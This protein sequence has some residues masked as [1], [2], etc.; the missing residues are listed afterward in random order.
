MT[1]SRNRL[2]TSSSLS[3][4]LVPLSL[5]CTESSAAAA[6]ALPAGAGADVALAATVPGGSAF[7]MGYKQGKKGE[8]G[9]ARVCRQSI[10]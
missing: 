2:R 9:G 4:F 6:G 8:G 10:T 7:A 3:F 1:I 5:F